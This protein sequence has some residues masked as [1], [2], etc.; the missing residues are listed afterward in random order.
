MDYDG[1]MGVLIT[2]LDKH[3][4]DQFEIIG[5]DKSLDSCGNRQA[6]QVQTQRTRDIRSH[7]H[8]QKGHGGLNMDQWIPIAISGIALLHS[9][10]R[11]VRQPTILV[12]VRGDTLVIENVGE[13]KALNVR[14]STKEEIKALEHQL[15]ATWRYLP[16]R[17]WR[18]IPLNY[19][20]GRQERR[21]QHICHL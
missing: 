6:E 12:F 3:N 1:A 21:V 10:W 19:S 18:A 14:V 17:Q 5:M 16:A 2:F 9:I 8:P 20:N 13:G 7:R 15:P 4:A 11:G